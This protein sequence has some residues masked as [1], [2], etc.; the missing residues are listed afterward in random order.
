MLSALWQRK[1]GVRA[2]ASVHKQQQKREG[3]WVLISGINAPEPLPLA[4]R[5]SSPGAAIVG[6]DHSRGA[7]DG[8][9][10]P[11]GP[12]GKEQGDGDQTSPP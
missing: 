4:I 9:A 5:V 10:Q 3:T 11:W 8:A 7:G 6:P 2:L 12:G 1:S